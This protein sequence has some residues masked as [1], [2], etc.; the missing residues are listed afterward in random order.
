MFSDD[1]QIHN[2][3]IDFLEKGIY[4]TCLPSCGKEMKNYAMLSCD[5]DVRQQ[6]TLYVSVTGCHLIFSV[7][8]LK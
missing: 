7:I 5:A 8:F 1:G 3:F 6:Q 4:S 2:A